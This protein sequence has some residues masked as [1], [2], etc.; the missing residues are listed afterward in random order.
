MEQEDSLDLL[1]LEQ[2]NEVDA[3]PEAAPFSSPRPKKPWLLMGVGLAIIVLATWII[4]AKFGSS[5]SSVV[6]DLDAPVAVDTNA[7]VADLKVPEKAAEPVKAEQPK[8]E[9]K[10]EVK[11]EPAPVVKPVET[12]GNPIR[13]VEDRKEVTFNPDKPATQKP[14]VKIVLIRKLVKHLLF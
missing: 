8:P 11:P 2:E 12:D 14:V 3:L 6:V 4:I 7:P 1:D 9:V 13:V 10:P 5:S